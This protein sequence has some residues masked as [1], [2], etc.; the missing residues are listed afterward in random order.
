M[1]KATYL[2]TAIMSCCSIFRLFIFWL[3]CF[4][5]AL[6][7]TAFRFRSPSTAGV[8]VVGG[9]SELF[10]IV[11]ASPWQWAWYQCAESRRSTSTQAVHNPPERYDLIWRSAPGVATCGQWGQIFDQHLIA[12]G[13]PVEYH[14]MGSVVRRFWTWEFTWKIEQF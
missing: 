2:R 14:T 7:A 13:F 12:C 6:C 3:F 10:Q 1:E 8:L 5:L 11:A 9:R 4:G